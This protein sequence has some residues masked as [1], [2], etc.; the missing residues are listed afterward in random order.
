MKLTN[1]KNNKARKGMTLL[2]L[3]VVI[4]VLL[5][6]IAVLLIGVQAWMRSADRGNAAM[7]IR[8]AQQGVRGHC[9]LFGI[10][11]TVMPQSYTTRFT[12][13]VGNAPTTTLGVE[14]FDVD[15]YVII[16]PNNQNESVGN[17]PEHPSAGNTF[18][19]Q[20]N[21]DTLPPLGTMYITSAITPDFFRP[22]DI[23]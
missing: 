17:P 10:D 21:E 6:L 9:N 18:N 16:D 2:E 23:E 8:N 14:V 4:L 5:S 15:G 19:F 12:E 1:I 22:Q 11:S 13:N 20:T 7:I 3:T